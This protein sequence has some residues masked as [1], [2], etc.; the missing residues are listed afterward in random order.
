MKTATLPTVPVEPA[1]RAELEASLEEGESVGE[2]IEEAVAER[3]QRRKEA[4]AAFLERGLESLAEAER[5]GVY[6]P[7]EQVLKHLEDKLEGARRRMAM[8]SR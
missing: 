8:R 5:T 4:R 6:I 1:L 7:A 2:F 3:L